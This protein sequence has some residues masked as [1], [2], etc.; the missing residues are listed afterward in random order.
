[1]KPARAGDLLA[2]LA[3][4]PDPRGR[5]GRRHSLSAMLTAIVSALLCGARGYEGIVEWVHDLPLDFC[6]WMAFTRWPPKKDAFRDLLMK[7][8]PAILEWAIQQWMFNEV[9]R[10]E[11]PDFLKGISIDG[12]CRC[13]ILRAHSKAVHLLA[14]VDHHTGGV[15]SQIRVDEKTNEH[16]GSLVLLKN[17]LLKN[18]VIVGDAIFCQRDVCEQVLEAGGDYLFSVKENQSNLLRDIE[19][20][21]NAAPASFSSS[22]HPRTNRRTT[23]G[24]HA[25]QRS[26]SA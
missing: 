3:Q 5:K 26:R 13:G 18:R 22:R 10:D 20:E 16:K 19:L 4:V 17:L 24:Q 1:M 25:R 23:D 14:A 7:L 21:F 12:K 6:H 11:P 8:D 9:G 2:Y 15:L